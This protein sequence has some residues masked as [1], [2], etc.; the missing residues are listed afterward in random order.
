MNSDEVLSEKIVVRL[1]P[2]ERD[3]LDTFARNTHMTVSEAVR[4]IMRG[5][6]ILTTRSIFTIMKTL[7]EIAPD[8]DAEWDAIKDAVSNHNG[9]EQPEQ[10]GEPLPES[11]HKQV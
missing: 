5:W 7:P 3:I 2:K 6:F 1:S 9:D 4:F 8:M 11:P 10:E